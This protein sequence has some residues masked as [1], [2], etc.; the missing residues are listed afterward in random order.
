MRLQLTL[1]CE[2]DEGL[3]APIG[4]RPRP[5]FVQERIR[6]LLSDAFNNFVQVRTDGNKRSVREVV[7]REMGR[8][9]WLNDTSEHSRRMQEKVRDREERCLIAQSL[10]TW[11]LGAQVK[12][13]V[14]LGTCPF[15]AT[16]DPQDGTCGLDFTQ[17]CGWKQVLLPVSGEM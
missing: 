8:R 3:L 10:S 7:E 12:V 13:L 15:H 16:G 5:E 1:D 14:P 2:I 9:H 17:D 11:A 4:E 6:F